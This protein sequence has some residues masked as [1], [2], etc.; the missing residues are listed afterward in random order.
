MLVLVLGVRFRLRV[1]VSR[2]V[3]RKKALGDWYAESARCVV[4]SASPLRRSIGLLFST[5]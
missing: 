1:R 5:R 3:R 2:K 4:E